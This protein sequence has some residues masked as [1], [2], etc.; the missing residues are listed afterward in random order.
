MVFSLGLNLAMRSGE[1]PAFG[2]WVYW[3]VHGSLAA[4]A[5]GV[6]FLLG[7]P[8][9]GELGRAFRYRR[10]SVEALFVLSAFG[11]FTGSLITSLTGKGSVYYEVVSIVLSVYAIGKQIGALQ[12][13][14]LARA[15]ADFREQH[16]R[17][18]IL[19]ADNT[20]SW[21]A[22]DQLTGSERVLVLPGEAISVD[23]I[24]LEGQG[25]IRETALTG[26]PAPVTRTAGDR[27]RAGTWSLDGRFIVSPIINEERTIDRILGLLEQA[28]RRPGHLQESADRLMRAF[29]PF[30]SLV[31]LGTFAGWLFLG[32]GQWWEAL[33]N[34]MAV[35]LVACPCALGL[36]MPSGI[37]AG[38]YHLGERGLIGRSGRLIDALGRARTVIFDKT[39][40]LTLYDP[41]ADLS[42]LKP[43]AM[44]RDSVLEL[45]AA[46]ARES[47]HPVSE[48]LG[49]M[50][51]EEA[52]PPVES[53]QVF[54]G[55]GLQGRVRGHEVLLGEFSFLQRMGIRGL[56]AEKATGKGK[57]IHVALDGNSAGCLHLTEHLRD[58]SEACLEALRKLGLSVR[59]FS[60][61]ATPQ[62]PHIGGVPVE[63]GLSAEDKAARIEQLP[64]SGDRVLFIG[65]GVNDVLAMEA[66]EASIAVDIGTRLATEFADGIL[67]NAHL[68]ALPGAV[69]TARRILQGLRGNMRFALLYNGVGMA[70]AAAG[71][72]HPVVAA[73]LMVGSSVLVSTRAL[74]LARN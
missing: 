66:S 57:P 61:D 10:W 39:G 11:A 51:A 3:L 62:F 68:E 36:A 6:L 29:V 63:G 72:L 53:V 31:A 28:R 43:N 2:S 65:D 5:V 16:Q 33:F 14:K 38:L 13:G 73:L 58:G 47:H 17:A 4:S 8:L 25:Y 23:G 71:V 64:E 12:K 55:E 60:G 22:V 32:S 7:G 21:K 70:L 41:K 49:E 34:A 46:L 42:A 26:E 30:V 27:V 18:R 37:W 45:L 15:I 24:L 20:P 74:R 54:P 52:I 69:R 19:G 40:T 9:F 48:A 67:L 35:L 1:G 56:G 50:V 59:I 44:S